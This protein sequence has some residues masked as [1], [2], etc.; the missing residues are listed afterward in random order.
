M[1]LRVI[2]DAKGDKVLVGCKSRSRLG[3]LQGSCLCCQDLNSVT[4]IPTCRKIGYFGVPVHFVALPE[5][6]GFFKGCPDSHMYMYTAPVLVVSL[7]HVW[8][9]GMHTYV[10]DLPLQPLL[11]LPFTATLIM[12]IL[13][14]F[15]ARLTFHVTISRSIFVNIFWPLEDAVWAFVL[16]NCVRPFS[17]AHMKAYACSCVPPHAPASRYLADAGD[18]SCHVQ[19][20]PSCI[21]LYMTRR[22][23]CLCGHKCLRLICNAMSLHRYPCHADRMTAYALLSHA[24]RCSLIVCA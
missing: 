8:P 15:C 10:L 13:V 11:R 22:P 20:L 5:L 19:L 2:A 1:A 23:A 17:R 7:G 14:I 12:M 6:H 3:T 16:Q 24:C 9:H 18:H 21:I 4:Q